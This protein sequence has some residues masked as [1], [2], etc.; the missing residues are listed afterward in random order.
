MAF[1]RS[2]VAQKLLDAQEQW[3]KAQGYDIIEVKT[4]GEFSAMQAFLQRNQYGFVMTYQSDEY[5]DERLI[6]RKRLV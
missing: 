5:A 2:G 4:R 3:A 6:Y 1:R